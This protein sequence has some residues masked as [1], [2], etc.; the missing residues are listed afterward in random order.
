[1]KK[2]SIGILTMMLVSSIS[3]AQRLA[4]SGGIVQATNIG[5]LAHGRTQMNGVIQA[6]GQ[7]SFTS[8]WISSGTLQATNYGSTAFGRTNQSSFGGFISSSGVGSFVS[9]ATDAATDSLYSTGRGSGLIGNRLVNYGNYS[10]LFGYNLR[11]DNNNVTKIGYNNN[12]FV[13]DGE[14]QKVT[15]QNLHTQEQ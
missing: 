3:F 2:V 7:G 4:A 10:M 9:G 5:A 6:T 13:V 8:G 1:M 11:N 14:G 12:Q 15:A